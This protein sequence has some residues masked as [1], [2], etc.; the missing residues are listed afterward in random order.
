MVIPG[1]NEALPALDVPGATEVCA[2]SQE[3]FRGAAAHYGSRF[4]EDVNLA[5]SL[6][7]I[8]GKSKEEIEVE[9]VASIL[10]LMRE[11]VQGVNEG[12]IEGS[13]V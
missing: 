6:A 13:R 10:K 4:Y 3:Q 2:F 11:Y 7:R 9:R 12:R 8:A 5:V 1:T